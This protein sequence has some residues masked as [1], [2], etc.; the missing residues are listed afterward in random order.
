M[1]IEE[2]KKLIK[3]V[4][5]RGLDVMEFLD[6]D[7]VWVIPGFGTYRGKQDIYAK[8]LAPT[9]KLMESMGSSVITN[10]IAEG[11]YVV[12]E[13]YAK[14]R[15]TKSGKP[16]NNTYCQVYKVVDGLVHEIN[17]YADTAFAKDVFAGG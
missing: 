5:A 15:M 13:S 12:V 8:L 7:A 17:E 2:N 4:L 10:I 14:D 9:E 3:K 16:Y 1:S 6:E 11:D